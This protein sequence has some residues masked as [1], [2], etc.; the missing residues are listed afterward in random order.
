MPHGVYRKMK[1]IGFILS[2]VVVLFSAQPLMSALAQ[3]KTVPEQ[4]AGM[5]CCG[6]QAHCCWGAE[7]DAADTGK[8]DPEQGCPDNCPCV[9]HIQA[10]NA[11]A[12]RSAQLN[13]FGVYIETHETLSTPYHLMLPVSIWHPPQS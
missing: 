4:S 11:I 9:T 7:G 1:A 12:E 5:L 2:V 3:D 8:C 6:E 13:M 10:V